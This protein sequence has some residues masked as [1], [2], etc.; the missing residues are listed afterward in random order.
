[1]VLLVALVP[2]AP[3]DTS[4]NPK[5]IRKWICLLEETHVVMAKARQNY[6]LSSRRNIKTVTEDDIDILLDLADLYNTVMILKQ[7]NG[8]GENIREVTSFEE[9]R[10][11]YPRGSKG[12]RTL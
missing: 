11:K 9:F 6:S 3:N 1:M 10:H 12:S 5:N 4:F 2:S 7:Q 8:F